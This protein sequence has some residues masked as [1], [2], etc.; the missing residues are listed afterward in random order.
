MIAEQFSGWCVGN[1]TTT[2]HHDAAREYGAR[3]FKIVRADDQRL[4]QRVEQ[5]NEL[6]TTARV[7]S[8]RRFVKD[9]DARLH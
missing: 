7:E 1:D 8:C 4:A 9:K 3:Q 2:T 5:L 6:S